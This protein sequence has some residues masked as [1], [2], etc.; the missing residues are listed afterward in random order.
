MPKTLPVLLLTLWCPIG[1]G[2]ENWPQFR[3]PDGTGHS[4]AAF[5]G[6][7][8]GMSSEDRTTTGLAVVIYGKQ[9]G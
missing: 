9:I 3:G 1:H 6:A 4:A 8:R 2:A 5:T 7:R